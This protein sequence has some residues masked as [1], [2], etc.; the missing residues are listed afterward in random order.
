MC[1]FYAKW[2]VVLPKKIENLLQIDTMSGYKIRAA[3]FILFSSTILFAQKE[4]NVW[5][6]GKNRGLDFNAGGAPTMLTNNTMNTWEGCASIAD[7]CSG[8]LLFYTNGIKVW[9][10]NHNQM[11]NGFGL[12]GGITASGL[13]PSSS[14]QSCIIVP[15]WGN[16]NIY[17]IFTNDCS[18][19][20]NTAGFRYSIVD[21]SLNGGL[22]NVT[23]KNTLLFAP[24]TEKV[25]AVH[26]SNK[27][28]IWVVSHGKNDN[29]FYAYLVSNAGVSAPV[30]TSV[31]T[32]VNWNMGCMRISSNGK[33][34]GLCA[35]TQMTNPPTTPFAE[36]FNFNN[37]TGV[38][39][40]PIKID[41]PYYGIEFSPN[42]QLLYLC[43]GKKLEQYDLSSGSAATI[44]ASKYSIGTQGDS[45][46]AIQQGPDKKIYCTIGQNSL[47]VIHNPN[48]IGAAVNVQRKAINLGGSCNIGLTN[49]VV[50]FFDSSMFIP[51]NGLP[52]ATI[53]PTGYC[54]NQPVNFTYSSSVPV[55]IDSIKWNFGDAASGV[56][57][58]STNVNPD[59]IYS[60]S[61]IFMVQMIRYTACGND[62]TYETI[63]IKDTPQVNLNDTTLC[64]GPPLILESGTSAISYLWQDGSAS[65]MLSITNSGSYWLEITDNCGISRDTAQ[66]TFEDCQSTLYI[67]NAFIPGIPGDNS[68]FLAKGSN[69][70]NFNLKIFDR[71]GLLIFES[72]NINTG[73]DG[74]YKGHICQQDVYVWRIEYI[75]LAKSLE[76]ITENGKKKEITGH[77]TLLK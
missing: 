13:Q 20:G 54:I 60:S 14:S 49:F 41:G 28:D 1:N 27:K 22:G 48:S 18:E 26:H 8:E 69:V 35:F 47:H 61:S 3:I 68:L 33:W 34:L 55:T 57:N 74:K 23:T 46:W 64:Y 32:N 38:V 24:G 39:S 7:N 77:V 45:W 71:W 59:H 17:F 50:S 16:K 58:N 10:K 2:V 6:F 37:S 73:W 15:K 29:K 19:N 31:G 65:P 11:P 12:M 53:T 66:V 44:I 76:N 62:T 4:V 56:L 75:P 30:I 67:P 9:D 5:Y 43:Y 40:N 42:S 25:S 36:L 63:T 52:V 70:G 21:M 72:N 51:R